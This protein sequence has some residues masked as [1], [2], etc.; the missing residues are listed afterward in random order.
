M[1]R[2]TQMPLLGFR[3]LRIELPTVSE[4]SEPVA[5]TASRRVS[6]SSPRRAP[7]WQRRSVHA[8]RV[9]VVVALLALL[10]S[11]HGDS[12]SLRL[13]RGDMLPRERGNVVVDPCELMPPQ[14]SQVQAIVGNAIKVALQADSAGLF[15][16]DTRAESTRV[17]DTLPWAEGIAGYRGP[18]GVLIQMDANE[19]VQAATLSTSH[20]TDEH[21]EAVL[22]DSQFWDQFIGLT[23][24]GRKP[25]GR[26]LEFDGVTGATLTSLAAAGGVLRRLGGE[27]KSL[28]FAGPLTLDDAKRIWPDAQSVLGTEI[29]QVQRSDGST[30]MLL[31]TGSFID[32]EIGYQGPTELLIGLETEGLIE[33]IRVRDS[34]DNEPYVGYVRDE[35]YSF[36]PEFQG[37][38]LE[39]LALWDPEEAGVEGIS[40]ATMTSMAV[41]RTLPRFANEITKRGGVAAWLVKTERPSITSRWIAL[42]NSIRWNA[43]DVATI[44]LLLFLGVIH[45]FR[46]FHQRL[47]VAWLLMVIGVIGLW[48]GNLVSLALVSGWATSGISVHLAI[49]LVVIFAVA[50]VSPPTRGSNPYCNQLCPHGAVQQLLRPGLRS[51]RR[52][53]LPAT[54]RRWIAYLPAS[55][56]MTVYLL[57][58][59]WPSTDV[60]GFEPFHAYL[61]WIA[62]P[63]AIAFA[64]ATL[65]V[66]AFVPMAYCRHACGT[67]RLLDHLRI[68]ARSERWNGFDFGATGLLILAAAYRLL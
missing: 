1:A 62:T 26:S 27:G 10:P 60:S 23:W 4:G 13:L 43:V 5:G 34:L 32:D 20:D 16:V 38:S 57:L 42:W 66:S 25:N 3:S 40:G 19:T 46:W 67:G 44:C 9:A 15:R 39:S 14:L 7:D 31:R 28:L 37:M 65:L 53:Q 29:A 18:T 52:M 48:S 63:I 12:L 68:H 8:V 59:L 2:F 11:P 24:G 47:R 64:L 55:T 6:K 41:A 30:A 22:K 49:G 35:K 58:L 36:W 17:S 45:R 56:L 54:L 61:F 33:V 50:L 21:V 51:R